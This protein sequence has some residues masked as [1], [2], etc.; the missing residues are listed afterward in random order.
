M[1]VHDA[2]HGAWAWQR[3]VQALNEAKERLDVGEV[4]APDLP[5]HGHSPFTE[6][7]VITQE[8]YE[9]HF[10]EASSHAW[11]G[12]ISPSYLWVPDAA[13]RIKALVPDARIII[14]LRNPVE[15]LHSEFRYS[16]GL[17]RNRGTFD[18]FVRSGLPAL[19]AGK[20]P[21]LPFDPSTALWKGLYANQVRRYIDLFGRENLFIHLF[22]RMVDSPAAFRGDLFDFLEIDDME[23]IELT[24]VNVSEGDAAMAEDT[25]Q[26]LNRLYRDD[27]AAVAELIGEDLGHWLA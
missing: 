25:R 23:N 26:V 11:R 27:V 3:V 8:Q 21:M 17:G 12:K 14:L 9:A 18:D 24:K 1:L 19:R 2:W 16:T 13:P 10:A 6:I 20:V 4:L 7:R 5:G 15:R 22:E